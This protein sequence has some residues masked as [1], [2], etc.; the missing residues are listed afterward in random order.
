MVCSRRAFSSETG[1]RF[2]IGLMMRFFLNT[3]SKLLFLIGF[4]S[5]ARFTYSEQ[6]CQLETMKPTAPLDRFTLGAQTLIDKKTQLMWQK[7]FAG[8]SGELCVTGA[9]QQMTWAVAFQYIQD[10][11]QNGGIAGYSD[12]RLPNIRELQTIAELQCVEPSLNPS[13]FPNAPSGRTWSSSPYEFYKH[14]SWFVDFK[15]FEVTYQERYNP[16]YVLLVRNDKS[17]PV[18]L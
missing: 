4:M 14:Y 10:L 6:I 16:Y 11:N 2:A 5:L 13:L 3:R 1:E 17:A 12:W 9:P 15:Y 8:A 7:C 18:S